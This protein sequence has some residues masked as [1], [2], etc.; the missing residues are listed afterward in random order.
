M[1]DSVAKQA[2]FANDV[3][4]K[5]SSAGRALTYAKAKAD[6]FENHMDVIK[7]NLMVSH[8][9]IGCLDQS[10]EQLQEK[11]TKTK[12]T[13]E[14]ERKNRKELVEN[15]VHYVM[16]ENKTLK[17]AKEHLKGLNN[18]LKDSNETLKKS[19]K[20]LKDSIN[21][22]TNINDTLKTDIAKLRERDFRQKKIHWSQCAIKCL[23]G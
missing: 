1:D 17:D 20:T 2:K 21:V 11:L 9:T 6:T 4:F 3:S 18:T 10:E 5:T 23:T 22:T 12:E 13:L 15:R 14:D 16:H 8:L 7:H 19:N